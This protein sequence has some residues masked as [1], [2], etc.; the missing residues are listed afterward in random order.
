M[1]EIKSDVVDVAKIIRSYAP[2]WYWFAISVFCCCLLGF[3]FSR[4]IQPKYEVKANIVITE[5]S[6]ASQLMSGGL[7]GMSDLFGGNA[8]AEDEIEIAFSHTVLRA[9]AKE[10]GLNR[11]HRVKL[12]PLR[13]VLAFTEFPVE[14]TPSPSI[15]LDTLRSTILFRFKADTSGKGTLTVRANGQKLLEEQGVTLPCVAKTE[16][17]D[18][19]LTP[20][21]YYPKGEKLTTNI[22]LCGYDDAA[23]N[24]RKILNIGL[25]SKNSSIITMM[26][27]TPN[28]DYAK[29]VLNTLIDKYNE[30]G[31][32]QQITQTDNTARFINDRLKLIRAELDTTEVELSHY[33]QREGI[34]NLE[35]DGQLIY[36]R[37]TEAEKKLTEQE[38]ITHMARIT[39]DM[40]RESAKDNSLIPHIDGEK[41]TSINDLLQAYNNAILR[42][43]SIETSAKADNP[44]LKRMDEQIEQ[45]RKNLISSLETALQRSSNLA[46]EYRRVYDEAA[47]QVNGLP[48]Q[49]LNYR[50]LSRNQTIQEEIYIFLLQKQEETAIMMSN[51]QPKGLVVDQAYSLNEDI[52]LGTSTILILAFLAGMCIPPAL[53]YVRRMFRTKFQTREEVEE[54]T[55]VPVLGEICMDHSGES[56]VVR[57]GGSS[58]IAELFR[59]IRTNLQFVTRNS[60]DKVVMV[61]STTSGEGKSFVAVNLAASIAMLGKRTLL[62]GMDIR[63]PRL[64]QYLKLEKRQRRGLTE[65]L[66]DSSISVEDMIIT[67]AIMPGYDVIAAGPVPPNPSEMLASDKV[68]RMFDKLRDMYDFIIIDSAPVGMVSDS[69]LLSRLA[70]ATIYV[71]RANYTNLADLRYASELNDQQR[72]NRMSLVVNGTQ[73]RKGYGYGYGENNKHTSKK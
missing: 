30:R 1:K 24:L 25:A 33:K 7:S 28:V 39:L 54:L 47:S 64:I 19:T 38:V 62:I 12:M 56:L 46:K 58:S 11:E 68:D 69:F 50:A 45:M 27:K 41:L 37:M 61:T 60:S 9:V 13:H 51:A 22:K 23:E 67:D 5:E 29:A 44:T 65:Y 8:N 70:D 16:Y 35:V 3:L 2:K 21:E 40:V 43:N 63:K 26:M 53:V 18:F 10:L 59:L 4:T 6:G 49:E 66:S 52:S 36:Q 72:L 14:V 17:G 15:D 31:L 57:P 73:T 20:T 48:R 32:T 55:N 34:A 42:R 71:C